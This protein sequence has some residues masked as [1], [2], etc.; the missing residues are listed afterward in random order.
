MNKRILNFLLWI[1][2][3]Y[4]IQKELGMGFELNNRLLGL[5]RYWVN[6][7]HWKNRRIAREM[8]AL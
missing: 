6:W 1:A 5:L 3:V 8:E 4:A 7:Q 2:L